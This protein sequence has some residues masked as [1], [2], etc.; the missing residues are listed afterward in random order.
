MKQ[1]LNQHVQYVDKLLIMITLMIKLIET[2]ETL[3]YK[4]MSHDL[5]N[6]TY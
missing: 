4:L 3:L 1:K 5:Y 2:K 6:K